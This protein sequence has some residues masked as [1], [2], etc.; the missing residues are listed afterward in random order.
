MKRSNVIVA[1]GLAVFV[2]GAAATYFVL[3]GDD[4]SQA[5][6][7]ANQTAVL[8]AAKPIPAGTTGSK[9]LEQG[10][11][12]TKTVNTSSAPAGA[13]TNPQDI[14]GKT[15]VSS[16]AEGSFLTTDQFPQPQTGIGTLDIPDGLTALAIQLDYIQGVAGFPRSGDRIDIYG[17]I[18]TGGQEKAQLVMQNTEVL[19]V[20]T[21]TVAAGQPADLSPVFL[22]AVTPPQAEKLV[23]LTTFQSLYFSLVPRDAAPVPATPGVGLPDALKQLS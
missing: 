12:D 5:A 8:I 10:M 23:Y 7:A 15:A 21:P 19:S 11:V 2:V 22:V 16:I 13:L 3:R 6:P 4:S 14:V 1:L 9:A 17:V 18:K 20:S